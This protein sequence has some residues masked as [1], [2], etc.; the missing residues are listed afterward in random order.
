M[1]E[2][3]TA[4]PKDVYKDMGSSA[5]KT[6]M[7]DDTHIV[8]IQ[9]RRSERQRDGKLFAGIHITVLG[10]FSPRSIELPSRMTAPQLAGFVLT[11]AEVSN[12][13][14]E[15]LAEAMDEKHSKPGKK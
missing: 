8:Q 14:L 11:L 7:L 10:G 1:P 13:S 3:T 2:Q 12:I 6:I 4:P 9:N 15:D 5:V